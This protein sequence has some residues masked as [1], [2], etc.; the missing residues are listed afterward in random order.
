[1]SKT[2]YNVDTSKPPENPAPSVVA[3]VAKQQIFF[4]IQSAVQYTNFADASKN[5][6]YTEAYTLEML[7]VNKLE[8]QRNLLS[9]FY[10]DLRLPGLSDVPKKILDGITQTVLDQTRELELN[11]LYYVDEPKQKDLMRKILQDI[12]VK[13]AEQVDF[14]VFKRFLLR[15]VRDFLNIKRMLFDTKYQ[16][17]FKRNINPLNKQQY[18][19]SIVSHLFNDT[20]V[21]WFITIH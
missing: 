9:I 18:A 15:F 1:M 5:G 20:D 19:Q 3:T 21:F 4:I 17:A 2:I 14:E 6:V 10:P 16:D 12:T 13:W 7:N 11:K 8:L